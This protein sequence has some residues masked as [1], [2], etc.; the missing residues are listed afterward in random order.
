MNDVNLDNQ[1]ERYWRMVC[2]DNDG[3]VNDAKALQH[4]K[5]WDVFVN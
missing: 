4:A 2:E 5:R 1:M 3:G